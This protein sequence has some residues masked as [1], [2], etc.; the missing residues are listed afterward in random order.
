MFVYGRVRV[1]THTHTRACIIRRVLQGL[2]GVSSP[3]TWSV[4]IPPTSPSRS[5]IYVCLCSCVYMCVHVCIRMWYSVIHTHTHTH[6]HALPTFSCVHP[7]TH[8]P[9]RRMVDC[10]G[11]ASP[12]TRGGEH[13]AAQCYTEHQCPCADAARAAR[14]CCARHDSRLHALRPCG[15]SEQRGA[16]A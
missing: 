5:P 2:S 3:A 11:T 9:L 12:R 14:G 10:T 15:S 16:R 4:A 13:A 8:T 1:R 7:H 6:T